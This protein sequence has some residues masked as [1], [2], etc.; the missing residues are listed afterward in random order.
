MFA[1]ATRM[2]SGTPTS[3]GSYAMT[4]Q[5]F[6][7]DANTADSDTATL[8][9]TIT[10]QE[11]APADTA[12]AFARTVANQTYTVGE[13]ISPLTLPAANG[14][15][16]TLSYSLTPTVPGLTFAAATR[17][18]NGTPTSDGG[19]SMTYQAIDGDANTAASDA[20]SLT[21]IITVKPASTPVPV[22]CSADAELWRGLRVCKRTSA[23][24][25]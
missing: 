22:G 8:T 15:N 9:F 6:D 21:F 24:R 7:G 4:Y 12:P 16:D 14:G 13:A 18:L 3:D 17:T 25:I 5:T 1:V 20:A 10:V 19:Y 11:P 23:G 2:L